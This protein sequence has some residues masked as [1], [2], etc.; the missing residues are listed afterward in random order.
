MFV[1]PPLGVYAH[2]ICLQAVLSLLR[3]NV[4]LDRTGAID[5][6]LFCHAEEP[7]KLKSFLALFRKIG[8]A[9]VFSFAARLQSL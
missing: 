6:A 5:L 4:H 8:S 7:L 9:I 2:I 3:E 1:C